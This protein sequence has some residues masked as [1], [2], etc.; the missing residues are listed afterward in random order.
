MAEPVVDM[1]FLQ[2]LRKGLDD[3]VN[4]DNPLQQWLEFSR[5]KTR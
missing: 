1:I 5:R 3:L 2:I 4:E